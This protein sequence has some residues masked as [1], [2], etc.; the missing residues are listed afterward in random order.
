MNIRYLYFLSFVFFAASLCFSSCQNG[1]TT[2]ENNS[3]NQRNTYTEN[4]Q[5]AHTNLDV[6]GFQTKMNE[7]NVVLI[8]VRKPLEV[9]KGKLEGA[10]EL[11]IYGENFNSEIKELDRE[12]TYLVYCATGRRS[13]LAS[14][15]MIE[16]GFKNV[17]NLVGGYNAWRRIILNEVT[18]RDTATV[19]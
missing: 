13:V 7:K 18:Y 10:L 14:R 8:D 11:D 2:A 4:M 5:R 6:I 15:T 17:Y 19:K 16:L 3:D 1:D 12:K 9:R